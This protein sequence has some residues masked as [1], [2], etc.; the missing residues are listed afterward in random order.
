MPLTIEA[1]AFGN[2]SEIPRKFTCDGSNVS[3]ALSW[4]GVSK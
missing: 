1:N 2:G 4:K 3:P